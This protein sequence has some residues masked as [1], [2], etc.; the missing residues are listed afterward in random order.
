MTSTI[1]V[2]TISE[3]TSA[4]GVA[5]DG[6]TIKDGGITATTGAIVFNEASAD[7][8][9]RVESNGNS[10][11]IFVDGGNNRVHM[12]AATT[13]NGTLNIENASNDD[14]LVL[15]STDAD[16][17]VG[18]NLKLYRNS[19]SPADNDTLG[20]LSF[21]G[22]NDNSQDFTAF[23][24]NAYSTDVSDGTE[25][26]TFRMYAIQGGSQHIVMQITPTETV[27]NDGTVD[28]DFRVESDGN[29]NMLFVDGG[30]NRVGVGTASPTELL[31]L[32][33]S[34]AETSLNIEGG[35]NQSGSLYGSIEFKNTYGGASADTVAKISGIRDNDQTASHLAF[36][37]KPYNGSINERLRLHSGGVLSASQGIAL[38]VG[39]ANTASNVLDD[40][41]EG[42]WTMGI[43][44]GSNTMTL[45][46]SG[47]N[48]GKY[49]KVGKKVYIQ[50]FLDVQAV[51]SCSGG[52]TL[53][54]L[55]FTA[56]N[57]PNAYGA[58]SV[59]Y[60]ASL[61]ITAGTNL[62]GYIEGNTSDIRL[63][64]WDSTGG[65]TVLQAGELSTGEFIFSGTYFV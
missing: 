12:G 54:G 62:A 57:A 63:R 1:K 26:G 40:Y 42:T 53:T 16:A 24:M 22:R 23:Q 43:T 15:V 4:N 51:G 52:L 10:H 17:G 5:I 2:D 58:I 46:G 18:P 59:G 9:F 36:Y 49:I 41:E 31:H 39:T 28:Q 8:D 44:D 25:D 38:G 14:T 6:L 11:M 19:G 65:T 64:S 61:S 13:G 32:K 55:P 37:S 56:S 27:F 20:Q 7:V 47:Y 33:T 21:V 50:G 35:A 60:G 45:V 30:N 3:N 34:N 48:T 29:A